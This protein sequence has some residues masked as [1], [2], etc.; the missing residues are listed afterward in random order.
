MKNYNIKRSSLHLTQ[1]KSRT[2]TIF[3]I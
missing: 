1:E 2:L 3:F